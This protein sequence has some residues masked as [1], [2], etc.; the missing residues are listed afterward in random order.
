MF[1]SGSVLVW[2]SDWEVE[3]PNGFYRFQVHY[4]SIAVDGAVEAEFEPLPGDEKLFATHQSGAATAV[5]SS[6]SPFGKSAVAAVH[7]DRF[8]Y[9]SQDRYEIRVYD[10][11]GNLVRLV[12]RDERPTRVT[13]AHVRAIMEDVVD[14]TEDSNQARESRRIFREAPIPDFHPAYGPIYADALG[15]LWVEETR[16]PGDTTRVATIFDP[17][18]R[19]V[20]SLDLPQSFRIE[21]IGA[22]YIL[23]RW[24]DELGVEVL[25]LYD[26]TRPTA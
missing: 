1:S 19:M 22:D 5:L 18:G 25:E 6:S 16:L 11:T 7:G 24:V 8:F 3:S 4:R 21:E 13:D 23:G 2:S 9:G 20:G 10:Q 17:D 12:R 14:R 15:F 26:L